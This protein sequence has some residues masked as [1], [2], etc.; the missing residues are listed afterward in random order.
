MSN[1]NGR[2]QVSYFNQRYKHQLDLAEEYENLTKRNG[3]VLFDKN[4]EENLGVNFGSMTMNRIEEA[5][6]MNVMCAAYNKRIEELMFHKD[7]TQF[8]GA[9]ASD[10]KLCINPPQK[11]S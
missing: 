11:T 5:V 10:I 6:L 9:L 1:N 2:N 3:V 8:L 4:E 7:E